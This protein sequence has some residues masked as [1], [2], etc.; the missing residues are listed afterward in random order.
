MVLP[1]TMTAPNFRLKQ[2]ERVATERAMLRKYMVLSGLSNSKPQHLSLGFLFKKHPA[3]NFS[4][5]LAR[6][7]N[8]SHN[9]II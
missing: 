2:V 3:V 6:K 5:T 8:N 4:N 7:Q 9:A 1:L